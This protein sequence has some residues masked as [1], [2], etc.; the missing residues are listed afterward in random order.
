M[1]RDGFEGWQHGG[2]AE[3]QRQLADTLRLLIYKAAP[4]LFDGLDF[5]DD[6][7]FLDPLLFAYFTDPAPT[8]PLGQLLYGLIPRQRRPRNVEL[9]TDAGGRA[10]VPGIGVLE[11]PAGNRSIE[12]LH[13]ADPGDYRC[14]LDGR[15]LPARWR[16]SLCIPGTGIEVFQ[17]HHPL[18]ER[19]FT[20]ATGASVGVEVVEA[21]REH[22]AHLLI[23]FALLR[24]HC[25]DLWDEVAATT[26]RVMLYRGRLPN[27][28]ATLSAHGGV[29]FNVTDAIDEV[30][31][32]EDIAHQCAHV[33]FNAL[34]V[35]KERFLAVDPM[36]PL[37]SLSGDQH[38]ARS[39]YSAL[40]GLFT[41]TVIGRVLST[42]WDRQVFGGRQSHELLGRLGFILLKFSSDLAVL[43]QPA[44]FTRLGQ[45]CYR[46]FAAAYRDLDRRYARLVGPLEYG[47]QPYVFSYPRFA[48][49][50]PRRES[51]AIEAAN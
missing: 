47:N 33:I 19:F 30:A 29:F 46:H 9:R 48:E 5:H 38:E 3:G 20:D 4:A 36:T 11:T 51:A 12:L 40:H 15:T 14:R 39:V 43:N 37:E 16:A 32:L 26:R 13:G 21:T 50:N 2:T 35:E 25:P 31:F 49:R 41:Y 42:C 23:A 22:H 8:L 17:E 28:F 6:R 7:P 34:T 1:K 24:E 44:V 27:S 45:R 10:H 18:L